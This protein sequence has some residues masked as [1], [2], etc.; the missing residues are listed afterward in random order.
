MIEIS[1]YQNK[2]RIKVNEEVWE[3][4]DRVSLDNILNQILS[5]K[6]CWGKIK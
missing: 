5:I 2:W 1:M 3:F 4:E 6:D